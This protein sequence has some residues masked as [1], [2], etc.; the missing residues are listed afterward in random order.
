MKVWKLRSSTVE[1]SVDG[2]SWTEIDPPANIQHLRVNGGSG[3][4]FLCRVE[5]DG[6]GFPPAE[7]E[8]LQRP[9]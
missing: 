8:I 3:V 7:T 1:G 2:E 9:P 6:M 5:S 4:R